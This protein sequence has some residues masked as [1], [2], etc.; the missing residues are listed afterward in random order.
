MKI[1][2]SMVFTV[3]LVTVMLGVV[4]GILTNSRNSILVKEMFYVAGGSIAS[5][6]AA[7]LLFLKK[8]CYR[9]RVPLL[10]LGAVTA[11]LVLMVI[12]HFSGIG[13][14]NGPFTFLMLL[15]LGA[16]SLSSLLFMDESHIKIFTSV[17]LGSVTIMFVYAIMQWQGINIFSWDAALTR[18]GRSTGSLGNPNLLGGFASASI[19]FGITYLMSLKKFSAVVRS[20]LA[21][22]FTG[23]AT[24]AVV[25]SGTRG[26]VI[27][28]AAGC[29]VLFLWFLKSR[30]H[31]P[32]IKKVIPAVL[33][34]VVIVAS[35][36]LPMAS[37]LSELDPTAENQGTLQVRKIIWSGALRLFMDSPL[38]G[39]GP[40]SFQILFPEVRNPSYSLLGVSHNTLH[41]HC[42]YLEILV[43]IGLLG[44]ILWAIF[45]WGLLKR[46]KDM[47][48][49]HAGA[50]AGMAA[51]LAES[52][53]SVHLRWPPT[54]WMFATLAMIFLARGSDVSIQPVI[55]RG[56]SRAA[57]VCL[58]LV[59]VVLALGFFAHYLPM[60]R[61]SEL[62]FKGKDIFLARTEVAMNGAY[63][64]AGQWVNS[65]DQASLNA[66]VIQ[67]QNAT[68]FADSAVIY[69]RLA[70]EIYPCDLG[71]WYAL[72][73]AHLTRYMV[74]EVPVPAMRSVLEAIGFSSGYTAEQTNE[75]LFLGMAAYDS[76]T[77]MAPNY[78]E[79]H[80]NLALGYSNMGLLEESMHELYL[81]Y[82]IHAHRREDYFNQVSSLLTI[83]P[84]S[85]DGALL[86]FRHIL[87]KYDTDAQGEKLENM[88]D[89]VTDKAC[90][91]LSAQP[92]NKAVLK[93]E[94][95]LQIEEILPVEFHSRL[96]E[97][98][99]RAEDHSPFANWEN[100][101]LL[102]MGALE[103]L[104]EIR[105]MS[106]VSAF[107]GS[108]FPT[109]LPGDPEFYQAAAL[110][111]FASEWNRD[112]YDLVMDIFLDQ[113]VID[114][115]L[116][117]VNALVHNE[118]F[119]GSIHAGVLEDIRTVRLAVAGSR[120][121]MREGY[122][123]PW[124]AGSLPAVISDSLHA[125]MV[126]DSLNS[127]WYRMELRMTFLLVTSYWWDYNIFA[128][129]Q[130]QYLLERIFYCRDKIREL[131]PSS[132]SIIVSMILSDEI[133]RI[134][135][136]CSIGCPQTVGL[137]RD[138]LVSGAPRVF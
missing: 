10:S 99:N 13:S 54:A 92:D 120:A 75:E 101:A 113:I 27:G 96:I 122:E 110:F 26:S 103:A 64:A 17:M 73:S 36:A 33:L 40:G 102:S 112:A 69:S 25:A 134:G 126:S 30:A 22:L 35:V 117:D 87:A 76:L 48:L 125:R 111:L 138:D 107:T 123:T 24:T 94:F 29:F 135:L 114:R 66:A 90:F 59:S 119:D 85:I 55:S 41:A 81:A 70:T 137:L 18:S 37:R 45:V 4:F 79:V 89:T 100:R 83:C 82:R 60:S 5:M 31:S 6:L 104:E 127:K 95:L 116:D 7:A 106:I 136:Y 15:S 129:G 108:T 12:M 23:V 8:P 130:N 93:E 44:L 1:R 16:L 71:A 88:F 74:I 2:T 14:T 86:Y 57:A 38:V 105:S 65:G 98:I 34:L 49:L 28:V 63:S 77:T 133:E 58:A 42:E 47:D 78:A 72:G 131:E 128:S 19:P 3:L 43:D 56:K 46:M 67:W 109:V 118:R 84:G 50:F 52:L 80:N 91:L 124:L 32:G 39:H 132:W 53:V 21:I 62:V 121:A 11:V 51:M 9:Q 68:A 97:S 20:V 115:N 61:S